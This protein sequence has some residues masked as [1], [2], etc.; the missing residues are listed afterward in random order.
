MDTRKT[1]SHTPS[2]DSQSP[3]STAPRSSWIRRAGRAALVLAA[4]SAAACDGS[5]EETTEGQGGSGAGGQGGS[6]GEG[7]SGGQGASGGNGGSG[8]TTS[9]AATTS[10]STETEEM[11][12]E[13]GSYQ[14]EITDLQDNTCGDLIVFELGAGELTWTGPDTFEVLFGGVQL[15]T[16][17]VEGGAVSCVIDVF[18]LEAAPD[19]MLELQ[20]VVSSFEVISSASF[21]QIETVSIPCVGAGCAALAEEFGISFPCGV[22]VTELFAK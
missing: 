5:G 1:R 19:A 4:L 22:V 10:S 8:T 15:E 17:T 6:G 14:G 9:S 16:C 13:E 11:L 12:L 18:N 3:P 2:L 21:S 7:G 20:S